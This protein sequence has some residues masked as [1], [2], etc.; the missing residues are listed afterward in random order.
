MM[1]EQKKY[2]ADYE[3]RKDKYHLVVDEPRHLLAK[4]AG[5]QISQVLWRG[6][7]DGQT[8]LCSGFLMRCRL[9]CCKD[10]IGSAYDI[11]MFCSKV[12]V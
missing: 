6:W 8:G 3:Q 2:R 12:S 9:V 4:I 5:D 11:G 10:V 1:F 7:L